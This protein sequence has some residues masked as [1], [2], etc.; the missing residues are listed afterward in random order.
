MMKN[1]NA[2]IAC[3]LNDREFRERR[4]I[5]LQKIG[6]AIIST[7]ELKNGFAYLFPFN[8]NLLTELADFVRFE[9]SCCPFLKFKIIIESN[10]GD[11]WLEMT[12]ARGTKDF[13][14]TLFA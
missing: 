8:D 7:K 11:I 10:N 14:S 4:K 12:G 1:K 2:P 9:R 13:L 6:S 5:V 3:A